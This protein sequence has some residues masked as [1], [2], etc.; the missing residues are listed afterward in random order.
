MPSDRGGRP[1]VRVALNCES[2]SIMCVSERIDDHICGTEERERAGGGEGRRRKKRRGRVGEREEGKEAE[3]GRKRER[4][5]VRQK[6]MNTTN[7]ETEN[8]KHLSIVIDHHEQNPSKIHTCFN[9]YG[10]TA[11]Y[12]Y[13][14]HRYSQ[15]SSTRFIIFL[16]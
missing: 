14:D 4:D 13:G 7:S 10:K 9:L 2:G 11:Y 16:Q 1:V 5:G 12:F 6:M 3:G 8:N 15:S